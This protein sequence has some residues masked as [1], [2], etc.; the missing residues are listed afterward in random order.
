MIRDEADYHS[1]SSKKMFSI[2]GFQ[3][4]FW[5]GLKKAEN[6]NPLIFQILTRRAEAISETRFVTN[7]LEK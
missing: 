5:L 7:A 4:S 2:F 3:E 1:H 6:C